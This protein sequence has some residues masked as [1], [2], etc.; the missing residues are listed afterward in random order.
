[1]K[2]LD[3]ATAMKTAAKN[4]QDIQAPVFTILA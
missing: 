3:I 4:A 2:A 1:V